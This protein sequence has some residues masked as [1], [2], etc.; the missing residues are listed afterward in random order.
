MP[1]SEKLVEQLT[2]TKG[3]NLAQPLDDPG[4]H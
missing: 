4:S 2:P 1:I 3:R